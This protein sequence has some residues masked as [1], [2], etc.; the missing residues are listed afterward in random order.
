MGILTQEE[1]S[2]K[3][4]KLLGISIEQPIRAGLIRVRNCRPPWW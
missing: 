1:F 4:A 2:A 3:K